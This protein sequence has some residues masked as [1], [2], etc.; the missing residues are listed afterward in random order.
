MIVGEQKPLEEVMELLGDAEKV[1]IVGCGTC[2]TVCFAGGEKEVGILASV[3]RMKS[4]FEGGPIE[5]DEVTVQRQCEWEYIDPLKDR[6]GDYLR[7]AAALRAAGIGVEVFPEPKKLGQQLKYADRRG[8]R[9]ALIAGES[10]FQAGLCQVKDLQ[11]GTK[12][13]VP[14]EADA[15]SIVAAVK[16]RLGASGP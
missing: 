4:K 3:L 7:L 8:F 12:Q 6:L 10:E 15:A 2:V 5:V 11:T 14:L 16:D 9:I 13:D 1:L